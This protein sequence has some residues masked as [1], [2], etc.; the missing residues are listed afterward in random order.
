LYSVRIE[1]FAATPADAAQPQEPGPQAPRPIGIGQESGP[2]DPRITPFA[3]SGVTM[4]ALDEPDL[5][6]L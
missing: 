6:A 1:R 5:N 4:R 2:S 3:H